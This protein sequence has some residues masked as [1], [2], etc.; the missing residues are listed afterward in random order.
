MVGVL[1]RGW[2]HVIVHQDYRLVRGA[3]RDIGFRPLNVDDAV[4]SLKTTNVKVSRRPS[5]ARSFFPAAHL[6]KART[7]FASS[8]F[9]ETTRNKSGGVTVCDRK[10]YA[11]A[12]VVVAVAG[13]LRVL[14]SVARYV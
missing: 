11:V 1:G 6:S 13:I 5:V 2:L 8:W 7:V 12:G 3:I 9:K 4:A 10:A 14:T